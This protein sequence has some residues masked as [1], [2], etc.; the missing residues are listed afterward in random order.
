MMNLVLFFFCS[1]NGCLLSNKS[2]PSITQ[3]L[4][5]HCISSTLSFVQSITALLVVR[6]LS[7]LNSPCSFPFSL[8]SYHTFSTIKIIFSTNLVILHNLKVFPT[9]SC[10][11]LIFPLPLFPFSQLIPFLVL[12]YIFLFVNVFPS[13][14][15]FVHLFLPILPF[16]TVTFFSLYSCLYKQHSLYS[17]PFFFSHILLPPVLFIY[18]NPYYV[19]SSFYQCHIFSFLFL[20]RSNLYSFSLFSTIFFLPLFLFVRTNPYHAFSSF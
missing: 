9:I 4:I 2:F 8:H 3:S 5:F 14:L 10:H 18:L 1:I 16:F 11:S 20:I 6:L 19:F 12:S 13:L 17:F 15:L 7:F